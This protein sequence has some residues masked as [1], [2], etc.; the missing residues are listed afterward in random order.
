MTPEECAGCRRW[1]INKEECVL[2]KPPSVRRIKYPPI[3]N[4]PC[5]DCLVRVVCVDLCHEFVHSFNVHW[6][7]A[8]LKD[9]GGRIV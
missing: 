6:D 9:K 4:C 1:D 7:K 2:S 8:L 5:S 3:L